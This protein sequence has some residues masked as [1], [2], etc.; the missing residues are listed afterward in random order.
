MVEV[1]KRYVCTNTPTDNGSGITTC[2]SGFDSLF[3]STSDLNFGR[4]SQHSKQTATGK[5]VCLKIVETCEQM[6]MGCV[7]EVDL[8]RVYQNAVVFGKCQPRRFQIFRPILKQCS[9]DL[10]LTF[11]RQEAWSFETVPDLNSKCELDV[12]AA[13]RKVISRLSFALAQVF[14]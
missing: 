8:R 13:L 1:K 5:C 3:G 6:W 10:T 9:T 11:V 14:A 4:V 12:H 7:V 2:W